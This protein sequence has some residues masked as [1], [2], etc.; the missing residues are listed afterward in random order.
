MAGLLA[1]P[2]AIVGS[3]GA[4]DSQS[5]HVSH[6]TPLNC[7]Q[8]CILAA[9]GVAWK[10]PSTICRVQVLIFCKLEGQWDT[11]PSGDIRR[12]VPAI[13]FAAASQRPNGAPVMST[14][15]AS[16]PAVS[17]WDPPTHLSDEIGSKAADRLTSRIG[18]V[19][20]LLGLVVLVISTQL[21][22]AH[23]NPKDNPAVF[24][25][26][27]QSDL[28]V[29]VHLGQFVGF[30]LVVGGLVALSYSLA[31]REDAAAAVAR[32][33]LAAAV[34]TGAS[35]TIL[36]AVDGIALKRSVDAWASAPPDQQLA[37]FSAAEAIRW[38]EIGVNSLSFSLVGL[39]LVLYGI[40]L[41]LGGSYPRW[42]GWLGASAGVA[43][44]IRGVGVS[45]QGFVP[46]IAALI[47]LALLALWTVTMA[48]MMWRRSNLPV[49]PARESIRPEL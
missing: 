38:I 17:A 30:L 3:Q 11:R 46:S 1:R 5:R 49:I 6:S 21:H 29:A 4:S 31:T 14:N 12:V 41:A 20:F 9:T 42:L 28:W 19:L 39:T 18:A 33:G 22:P 2:F 36:Q 37:A 45:Y 40:A 25:E 43:H 7:R 35:F 13:V 34:T 48:V 27:A 32:F 23:E 26:Y 16:A 10:A 8:A 15:A 24:R 44:L 47:G